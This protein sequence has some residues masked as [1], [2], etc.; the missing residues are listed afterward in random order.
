[1]KRPPETSAS[2]VRVTFQHSRSILTRQRQVG[3]GRQLK[4]SSAFPSMKKRCNCLLCV[5]SRIARRAE[6]YYVASAAAEAAREERP[7]CPG[8][9]EGALLNG[10]LMDAHAFV[11]GVFHRLTATLFHLAA[12][13]IYEAEALALFFPASFDKIKIHLADFAGFKRRNH[14]WHFNLLI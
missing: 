3:A 12:I 11:L 2:K 8:S 9:P 4:L 13:C 5:H 6:S 14:V 10:S 1:M 7:V